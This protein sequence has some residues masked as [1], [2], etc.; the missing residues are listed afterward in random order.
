MSMGSWIT[1]V[2]VVGN[3]LTL[4]VFAD[5]LVSYFLPPYHSVRRALDSIVEPLLAPIRRLMPPVGGL[6]FSPVLLFLAIQI[7]ER[8]LI[9]ALLG[10]G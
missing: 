3:V 7:V 1:I 6:D 2:R 8:L 5:I 10:L 4:V 9:Q